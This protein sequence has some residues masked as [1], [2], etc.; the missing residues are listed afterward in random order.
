[1]FAIVVLSNCSYVS[2]KVSKVLELARTQP[3]GTDPALSYLLSG[4][5]GQENCAL[6]IVADE[7]CKTS[8]ELKALAREAVYNTLMITLPKAGCVTA[9]V[10]LCKEARHVGWAVSVATDKHYP[11]T[12]DTFL[13]DFAVGVGAGQLLAGGLLSGENFSKYNRLL[14]INRADPNIA[15]VGRYFR[16]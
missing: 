2:Q 16:R 3:E 9:A 13:T 15:Y 12:M 11:E 6:Q 5:G 7:I 4:V 14:E 10:S 1:M 8:A